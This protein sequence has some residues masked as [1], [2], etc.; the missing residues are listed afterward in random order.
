MLFRSLED[1][2]I[3]LLKR[4]SGGT[5]YSTDLKT[6]TKF[7][8][9]GDID[10]ETYRR[11]KRRIGGFGNRSD[12]MAFKKSYFFSEREPEHIKMAFKLLFDNS[13]NIPTV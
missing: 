2:K 6:I 5:V 9:L 7:E 10:N 8:I 13:E 11:V 12:A 3:Y 4:L 1:K